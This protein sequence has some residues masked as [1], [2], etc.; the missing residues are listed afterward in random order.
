MTFKLVASDK[1]KMVIYT[2]LGMEIG[3]GTFSGYKVY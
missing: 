2:G 3:T 1:V